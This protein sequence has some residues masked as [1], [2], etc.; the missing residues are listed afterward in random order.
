MKRFLKTVFFVLCC[1]LLLAG[2]GGSGEMLS[3]SQSKSMD[4]GYAADMAMPEASAE[5]D[6]TGSAVINANDALQ[7]AKLIYRARLEMEST[8]FDDT[9]TQLT[10]AV[11]AVQG[12][13]E[14]KS[15]SNYS[16]GRH[17][18]FVIRVPQAQYQAFLSQAEGVGHITYR[19][20]SVENVGEAYYDTEL[21]LS[22]AKTKHE[23]LESLLQQA[24]DIE[25]IVQLQ[26]ALSDVEYEIDRLSGELRSYD[27]L[28]DYATIEIGL[29]EVYR[30]SDVQAQ[31]ASFFARLGDALC[32]GVKGFGNGLEMLALFIAYHLF[33]LAILVVLV[34][35]FYRR[36]KKKQERRES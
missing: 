2:C 1:A 21:R 18:D 31:K 29:S 5:T 16:G 14:N 23:R 33:P 9:L 22:T 12:Y 30:L 36:R 28:I 10:Q 4:N 13:F 3:A 17:G 27:R 24:K 6:E 11:D 19:N 20:E 35:L 8:A 7:D 26:N 15:V 25:T 34:V 32:S